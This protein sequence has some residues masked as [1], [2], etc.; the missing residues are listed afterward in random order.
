[1]KTPEEVFNILKE[2]FGDAVVELA[3]SQPVDPYIVVNPKEVDKICQ[4]LFDNEELSFNNLMNL[5]GVDDSNGKVIAGQNGDKT[6]EG[7]TLSVYYHI[8]STKH[9]HKI[10]IKAST[11]RENPEVNSVESIWRHADWHE[12]EAYDLVGIIFLNHPNLTR[13]LMPYDW[14]A[15]HPLRKDYKNPEFYHGMKVP[16]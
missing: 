3:A 8:E 16:Y 15:G 12:R 5:S 1:M 13:I 11:P 9:K 14:D 2:K 4:Y 7:G 10:V 6:I